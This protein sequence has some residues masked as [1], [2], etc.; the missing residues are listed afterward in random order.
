MVC[1]YEHI[2]TKLAHSMEH[3]VLARI[4]KTQALIQLRMYSEAIQCIKELLSGTNMPRLS[5]EYETCSD[6]PTVTKFSNTL[7]LTHPKNIKAITTFIEKQ[8]TDNLR[9]I[10]GEIL[11]AELT[12]TQVNLLISLASTCLDV[13]SECIVNRSFE[14]QGSRPISVTSNISSRLGSTLQLTNLSTGGTRL[15]RTGA[16]EISAGDLKM[17]LLECSERL[18]FELLQTIGN[19]MTGECVCLSAC[20]SVCLYL[21]VCLSACLCVSVSVCVCACLSVCISMCV[22]QSV[23]LYLYVCVSVCLYLY[24]CVCLSVSLCVCVRLSVSV[25]GSVCL[26]VY[27]ICVN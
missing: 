21:C 15:R 18:L 11:S 1:L 19:N 17:M 13:P 20:L 23:C 7:K 5:S 14:D 9:D 22:C 26:S 10:Y 4:Y 16:L 24:V 8:L 2:S 12:L 6:G 3:T 25:H 27:G